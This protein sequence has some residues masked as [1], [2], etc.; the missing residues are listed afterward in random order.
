M[1]T[2][3]RATRRSE[4]SGD[5]DVQMGMSRHFPIWQSHDRTKSTDQGAK[6]RAVDSP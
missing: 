4:F 5:G 3:V 1:G 6:Q 2:G